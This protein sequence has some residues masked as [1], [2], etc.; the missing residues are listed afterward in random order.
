[1]RYANVVAVVLCLAM[2]DVVKINVGGGTSQIQFTST[3]YTSTI[4]EHSPPSTSV[5]KVAVTSVQPGLE[6]SFASG[7]TNQAFSINLQGLVT[8][9]NTE[10]IDYEE[11]QHISLIVAATVGNESAYTTV[12]VS[13]QDINDN[14]PLF[15]QNKYVTELYERVPINTYVMQVSASDADSIGPNSDIVYRIIGGNEKG[16]FTIDPP[17][18]GMIK[19]NLIVDYEVQDSYRLVIEAR[20]DGKTLSLS[21]TCVVEINIIDINDN[22]PLLSQNKYVKKLYEEVPINTYVLQVSASD[23]DS[24]GPNSDIVYRIIG[25]NETGVFT[26][27]PP[28]SGMIKTIAIVDYEVQDS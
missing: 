28:K 13:L 10:A 7:N 2:S 15:S 12:W 18:S 20:D 23:A 16:V 5:V 14:P 6:F 4:P 22:P 24:I 11:S 1:M 27:E 17:K 26:I 25:G 3:N 19:T 8:V 9:S 21:S